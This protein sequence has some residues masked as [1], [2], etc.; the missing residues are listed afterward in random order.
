MIGMDLRLGNSTKCLRMFPPWTLICGSLSTFLMR[1]CPCM[2][3]PDVPPSFAR[4]LGSSWFA[5]VHPF[6]TYGKEQMA[7]TARTIRQDTQIVGLS[8][9]PVEGLDRLLKAFSLLLAT[10]SLPN[11]PPGSIHEP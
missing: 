6:M 5:I 2:L 7:I 10:R 8:R 11:E 1:L 3:H 4:L 9:Q